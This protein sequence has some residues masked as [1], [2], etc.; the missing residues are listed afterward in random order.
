MK[1][2]VNSNFNYV[3]GNDLVYDQDVDKQ[4]H[5]LLNMVKLYP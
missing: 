5:S 4:Q 2:K 3:V 1:E